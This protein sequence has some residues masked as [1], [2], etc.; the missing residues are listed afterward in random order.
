MK[1]ILLLLFL[2]LSLLAR[3]FD[4]PDNRSQ[5]KNLLKM[6]DLDYKKTQLNGCDYHYDATSCMDITIVESKSC[7]IEHGPE[8]VAWVQ[9]VP[10]EYFGRDFACMRKPTCSNSWEKKKFGSPICCRR[11]NA[12]YREMEADLYNLIPV[13][14]AFARFQEGKPF[15]LVKKPLHR[16]GEIKIG[17]TKI[18]PPDDVKGNIARVYLY[19]QDRYGLK[20]SKAEQK[21][22]LQWHES[23]RVDEH[24]CALSQIIHTVQGSRNRWIEEGC[25][26]QQ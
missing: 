14:S 7:T 24:E 26:K 12:Q 3:G 9:V 25:T 21:V 20:L 2:T 5:A 16:V 10:G 18:E 17:A 23:D 1:I 13:V 6:I 19:M 15:G 11:V 8:S 22:F 4:A